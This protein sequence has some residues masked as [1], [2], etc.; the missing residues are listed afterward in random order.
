MID[1]L[2]SVYSSFTKDNR[3]KYFD[4]YL[5]SFVSKGKSVLTFGIAKILIICAGISHQ[6][7]NSLQVVS[8]A[9]INEF[10]SVDVTPSR[11]VREMLERLLCLAS[12]QTDTSDDFIMFITLCQQMKMKSTPIAAKSIQVL[13]DQYAIND[14]NA[15]TC[16][17]TCC[18]NPSYKD[19]KQYIT[20]ETHV[21]ELIKRVPDRMPTYA[22]RCYSVDKD[23]RRLREE[24]E[25]EV[26]FCL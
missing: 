4:K 6:M 25:V 5:S 3:F 15:E 16:L 18:E 20:N 7:F 12:E 11:V 8:L 22:A 24:E 2:L 21:L 17:F 13:R 19:V 1:V 9:E 10:L 14:M 23:D 26:M